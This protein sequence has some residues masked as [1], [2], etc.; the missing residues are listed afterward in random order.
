MK[1]L[2]IASM[3]LVGAEAAQASNVLTL[4]CVNK[5]GTEIYLVTL[6]EDEV[7]SAQSFNAVKHVSKFEYA[8]VQ[9]QGFGQTPSSTVFKS[10]MFK[11]TATDSSGNYIF[12]V[13]SANL[14]LICSVEEE[15]SGAVR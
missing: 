9:R 3:L 11:A 6:E 10:G 8:T 1:Y 5:A 4:N 13:P 7:F 14:G 15:F 12:E 2:M